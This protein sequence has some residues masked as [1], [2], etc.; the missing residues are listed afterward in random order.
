MSTLGQ[1]L[2]G[3][4]RWT[5]TS[6]NSAVSTANIYKQTNKKISQCFYCRHINKD[7]VRRDHLYEIKLSVGVE[8]ARGCVFQTQWKCVGD[9]RFRTQ[10]TVGSYIGWVPVGLTNEG[11]GGVGGGREVGAD[12]GIR[13]RLKIENGRGSCDWLILHGR[14]RVDENQDGRIVLFGRDSTVR[15]GGASDARFARVTFHCQNDYSARKQT[16]MANQR[17]PSVVTNGRIDANSQKEALASGIGTYDS[18]P[19]VVFFFRF[20]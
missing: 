11:G 7:L 20:I 6:T 4:N 14:R 1:V 19:S 17:H 3:G 10:K 16:T 18:T 2:I 15:N 8:N 12:I 9:L 13:K 5:S